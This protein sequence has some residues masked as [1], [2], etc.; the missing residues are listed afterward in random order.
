MKVNINKKKRRYMCVYCLSIL[1]M[2]II[3]II[4]EHYHN[5]E[6]V[7]VFIIYHILGDL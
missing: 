3:N 5:Q 2:N 4:Y 6:E 7:C 1:F